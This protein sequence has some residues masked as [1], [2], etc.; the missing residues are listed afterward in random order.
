MPRKPVNFDGQRFGLLV[1]LR[2][3]P[4]M[5]GMRRKVECKCDCGEMINVMPANLCSGNTR[6]CGCMPRTPV[7]RA[8]A[9]SR[10]ERPIKPRAAQKLDLT[11]MKFARLTVIERLGAIGNTHAI[12]WLCRCDCGNEVNV[13]AQRLKTR[14]TRSCGCLQPEKARA[15]A[16]HGE[17]RL[18]T[19]S[20][21][22]HAWQQL[23][24]R[25]SN[26]NADCWDD[27]GGRGISVCEH[28]DSFENF[29][30]DMGRR[31]SDNHSLDRI[32][33]EG[34]YEPSNCRWAT[35]KQQNNNCR[36]RRKKS[37][38]EKERQGGRAHLPS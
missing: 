13:T 35:R 1:V 31:P 3:I 10:S 19:Y 18:G 9:R 33:N 34:N 11:G 24:Y 28:W 30:A 4:S 12:W 37:E 8:N 29:L 17:T 25:C 21:E 20:P 27:Y 26:P 5:P 38:L 2:D 23:K 6:S 14:W 22:Y 7:V 15:N 16:R 32:D 36:P